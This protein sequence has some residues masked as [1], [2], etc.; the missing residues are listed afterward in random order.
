MGIAVRGAELEVSRPGE[1][2]RHL[3]MQSSP[4]FDE[5]GLPRGCVA[6][7]ADVSEQHRL[8]QELRRRVDELAQ[9]DRL[10]DDFLAM[11]AHELR[12]PLAPILH[13]AELMRL[14]PSADPDIARSRDIIERQVR[15]LTRLVD[16]LL[17][18]ARITRRKIQIERVPTDLA[19]CVAQAIESCRGLLDGRKHRLVLDLVAEPL[20]VEGDPV[21]LV[22]IVTNLLHNA[23][24]FTPPQGLVRVALERQGH[25]AVLRVTDNG[26]GI[27]PELLPRIFENFVQAPGTLD[28]SLG[29]LGLGLA[30]VRA[31]VE[32]HRGKVAVRSEGPDRGSEFE[33]RLP[34]CA[35]HGSDHPH[36]DPVVAPARPQGKARRVLIV[37]DNAD[38]T[39]ML[40]R[41][42][43]S[44]GHEAHAEG[45]GT[46]ALAALERISPDVALIDIG[47]PGM[48]GRELVR[49]LRRRHPDRDWRLV[50][51]S[52]YGREEDKKLSLAA[53]F[54]VHLVK[55]LTQERLMELLSD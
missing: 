46:S 12:N 30:L 27:T 29:G 1:A 54:D 50:A 17:D 55:P 43:E 4:L 33:V 21:R 31:L 3:L 38:L 49:E 25:T 15:H 26:A 39:A 34:V 28:R 32:L 23:A 18:V 44:L 5:Q 6:A 8:Q 13:A 24:K 10:K 42:V 35:S 53:G 11:L 36:A 16:D 41:V 14:R 7:F 2:S 52:G 20:T 22:Q 45:D 40:K 9:A 51:M 37:E 48:D 19:R 47:L